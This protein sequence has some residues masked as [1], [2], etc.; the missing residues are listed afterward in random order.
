M[1]VQ[2]ILFATDFSPSSETALAVATSLAKTNGAELIIAH[3]E[4]PPAVYGGEELVGAIYELN[5]QQAQEQL[6]LVRPTDLTVRVRRV[7]LL[8]APA[9]EILGLAEKEHADLIVIGTHGRTGLSRLL[10][11]S[12]AEAIVRRASCPVLTVKPGA[13]VLEGQSEEELVLR[14]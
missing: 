1:N 11:G 6:D 2:K 3:S 13:V 14:G 5:T 4:V 8:G 12:I 9:D 10:M 7:L